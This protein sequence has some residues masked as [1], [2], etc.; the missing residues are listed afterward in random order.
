MNEH[1]LKIWPGFFQEVESGDKTF[2]LRKDDRGFVS[3]D[4]LHLREWDS[5]KGFTGPR[6]TCRVTYVLEGPV[7]GLQDGYVILALRDVRRTA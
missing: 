6:L 7:F 5:E 2:E 1:D 3:G 4:T